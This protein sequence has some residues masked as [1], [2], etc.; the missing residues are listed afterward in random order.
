MPVH[1]SKHT[2]SQGGDVLVTVDGFQP[3]EKV[4]IALYSSPVKLG[5]FDVRSTGQVYAVVTI[6]KRTQLGTHTIQVTGF[7][8]CR[9]AAATLEIVSPPGSGSSI[10]PWIVWLIAGGAV[11]LSALG[12]LIAMLLGWVPNAFAIGVAARAVP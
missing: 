12:I 9:V 10:F 1:L 4:V 5:T 2:V 11:G 7:Q 8:D 6:P 3:A